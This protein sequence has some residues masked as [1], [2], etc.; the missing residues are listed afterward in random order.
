MELPIAAA[1]RALEAGWIK[2]APIELDTVFSRISVR[3]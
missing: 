3:W 1:A 2:S